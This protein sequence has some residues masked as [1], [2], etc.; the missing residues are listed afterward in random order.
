MY[1]LL[2]VRNRYTKSLS[3]QKCYDW[4]TKNTP[5]TIE[6]TEIDTDFDVTTYPIHNATFSGVICGPDLIPKLKP[7][8]KGYNAVVFIYGNDLNGIRVSATNGTGP[9]S[10]TCEF[11]QLAKV[12]WQ[13]LNHEMFHAF[14]QKA[15]RFGAPIQDNMDTYLRDS[16]LSVTDGETN[17]TIAIK[18]LTPYWN[19]I[20][21]MTQEP[22]ATIKRTY[23]DKE[24]FGDLTATHNGLSFS[25]KTLELP[26]LNNQHNISCIPK[27]T[28]TCTF[29]RSLKYPLGT[30]EVQKVPNRSGIR[31]H[32]GNYATGSH[33]D[34]QGCILLGNNFADINIDGYKDIV[35]SKITFNLFNTFFNK[36]PFT[37]EIK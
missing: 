12:T 26:W 30:Y 36:E 4:F 1:K 3:F 13:T 24:T 23:T 16:D 9:L 15:I 11:I 14:F 17:R 20:T 10:S 34:I 32:V 35:N 22:K 6:V 28:Y 27:G 18:A 21:S 25:C 8:S 37:L 19:L 29:T 7:L 33:T 5:L 31:I 2:I